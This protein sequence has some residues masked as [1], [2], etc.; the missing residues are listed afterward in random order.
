MVVIRPLYYILY[1]PHHFVVEYDSPFPCCH[2]RRIQSIVSWL[3]QFPFSR[4]GVTLP[5]IFLKCVAATIEICFFFFKSP[6]HRYLTHILLT[7]VGC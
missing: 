3:M 5:N 4:N 7:F 2:L 1:F 6:L